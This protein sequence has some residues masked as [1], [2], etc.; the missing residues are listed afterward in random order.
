I[1]RARPFL[2]SPEIKNPITIRRSIRHKFPIHE[3]IGSKMKTISQRPSVIRQDLIFIKK[4]Q[5]RSDDFV[6]KFHQKHTAL[7]AKLFYETL[8]VCEAVD[9]CAEISHTFGVDVVPLAQ[10]TVVDNRLQPILL[11]LPNHP[12]LLSRNAR[13]VYIRVAVDLCNESHI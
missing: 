1:I 10:P 9:R 3:I 6:L 2:T 8:E 5:H 4:R 12:P 13:H 11:P 7:W